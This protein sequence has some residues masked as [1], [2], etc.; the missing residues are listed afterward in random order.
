MG[1]LTA[2]TL[3]VAM[4]ANLLLLPALLYRFGPRTEEA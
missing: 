4:V 2:L 3:G 1:A